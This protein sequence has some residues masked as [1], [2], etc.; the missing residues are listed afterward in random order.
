M[1]ELI[2]S[3]GDSDLD[4]VSNELEKLFL[5]QDR[6]LPTEKKVLFLDELSRSGMPAAAILAGMRALMTD[7][8]VTKLKI[9]TILGAARANIDPAGIYEIVP[10]FE[11][12]KRGV[13]LMVDDAKR[14]F[15]LACRCSN[16]ERWVAQGLARWWG[17]TVQTCS[18]RDPGT[19]EITTRA[20]VRR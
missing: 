14:W 6:P 1:N 2:T 5:L 8:D 19:G 4:A 7:D 11:C 3:W 17:G 9:S 15:A 20:L 16:G 13:V 10:C 12:D 18:R